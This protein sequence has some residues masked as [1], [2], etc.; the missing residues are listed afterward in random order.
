MSHVAMD[1]Q[2]LPPR[3]PLAPSRRRRPAPPYQ[4]C[5]KSVNVAVNCLLPAT[6]GLS[7]VSAIAKAH[8]G[9]VR[10]EP[11]V[12]GGLEVVVALPSSV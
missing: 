9:V 12:A 5:G 2:C 6:L 4:R 10:A 7:I 11:G 1:S 8:G 3:L